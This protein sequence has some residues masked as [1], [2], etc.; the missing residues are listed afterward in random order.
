MSE[1]ASKR[2][3]TSFRAYFT[4]AMSDPATRAAYLDLLLQERIDRFFIGLLR[5]FLLVLLALDAICA[6]VLV[7]SVGQVKPGDW[8]NAALV[9]ALFA[10]STVGLA[11]V[12]KVWRNAL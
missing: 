10:L 3:L 5:F 9:V 6:Y 4:E 12:I 11:W 7:I 2:K 8:L 1:P